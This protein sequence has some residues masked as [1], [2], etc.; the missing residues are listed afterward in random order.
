MPDTGNPVN[1]TAE[2]TNQTVFGISV[3]PES[4]DSNLA[5]DTEAG[6][7][8]SPKNFSPAYDSTWKP[9]SA[10]TITYNSPQYPYS[11][12]SRYVFDSWSDGGAASHTIVRPQHSTNYVATVTADYRPA[13]NFNYPPCGG[14]ATIAPASPTGTWSYPD[15]TAARIRSHPGLPDGP[16]P[17]GPTYVTGTTN[18]TT[19]IANGETLVFAKFQHHEHAAQVDRPEPI[20]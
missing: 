13:T 4:F 7:A 9:N 12:N 10:H 20:H 18:P 1:T 6:F 3:T 17:D 14:T 19:L 15:R 16:S 8:Y 5:I 11:D 2:F